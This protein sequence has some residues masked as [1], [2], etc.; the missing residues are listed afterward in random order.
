MSRLQPLSMGLVLALS[1][2]AVPAHAAS[3]SVTSEAAEVWMLPDFNPYE[4]GTGSWFLN[5]SEGLWVEGI[6][7]IGDSS[8]FTPSIVELKAL[9]EY[10]RVGFQLCDDGSIGSCSDQLVSAGSFN[11]TAS[12]A[13]VPHTFSNAITINRTSGQG[14]GD[15]TLTGFSFSGDDAAL[16]DLPDFTSTALGG[17]EVTEAFD[18]RFLG[19]PIGSYDATLT[20]MTDTHL[21]VPFNISG[22]VTAPATV[23]TPAALSAG[24]VLLGSLL[25]RRNREEMR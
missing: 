21:L 15:L 5:I 24:I 14:S 13:G 8:A 23:P 3:V 9:P 25:L 1:V 18:L 4:E 11:F 10:L 12:P 2:L 16:F 7:S 22:T 17:G 6:P 20:F 19:A